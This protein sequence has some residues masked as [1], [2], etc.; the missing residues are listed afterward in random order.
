MK[1]KYYWTSLIYTTSD[2]GNEILKLENAV[3]LIT[4]NFLKSYHI[5]TTYIIFNKN[6][7]LPFMFMSICHVAQYEHDKPFF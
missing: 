7:V 1:E 4:E 5:F 6:Y 2:I 3:V